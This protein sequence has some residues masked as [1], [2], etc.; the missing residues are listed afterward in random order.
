MTGNVW[1]WC[2]D[3]FDLEYYAK[4][5]R[6]NPP[7]SATGERRVQRGGSYLCHLSYCSRYRVSARFGSEPTSST[8]N[9]GFR[10]AAD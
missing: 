8:G 4:S 1:E 6:S 7:G 10:V 5:P 2:A 3:W 9:A